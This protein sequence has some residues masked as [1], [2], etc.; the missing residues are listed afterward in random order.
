MIKHLCAIASTAALVACWGAPPNEKILNGLCLDVFEGDPDITALLAAESNADTESFCACYA[1]TMMTM[2]D[3]I[4]LHKDAIY[5]IA[6]AREGTSLGA[7][8]AAQK[9]G[10]LIE[11]GVIDTFTADQFDETGKDL[12]RVMGSMQDNDGICP[13]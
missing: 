4:P 5:E 6:Q 1:A 7:E 12:Q 3:K 8:D 11:D 9:V 10:D 2:P 13:I